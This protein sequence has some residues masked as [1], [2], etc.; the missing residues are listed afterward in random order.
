VAPRDTLNLDGP[1][2]P[3][4]VSSIYVDS[5]SSI[6]NAGFSEV[7]LRNILRH[8]SDEMSMGERE[9][10]YALSRRNPEELF[11]PPQPLATQV[12]GDDC[13][14]SPDQLQLQFDPSTEG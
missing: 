9:L 10:R 7:D 5:I 8:F 11:E 3:A 2:F 6:R 13:A 4:C 14:T 1:K 12:V